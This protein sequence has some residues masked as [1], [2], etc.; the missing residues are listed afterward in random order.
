MYRGHI[1]ETSTKFETAILSIRDM[2]RLRAITGMDSMQHICIYM[3]ARYSTIKRSSSLG[4]PEHLA[5]ENIIKL[6]DT[7]GGGHAALEAFAAAGTDCLLYIFAQKFGT[8]AFGFDIK[9]GV[10]DIQIHKNILMKLNDIDVDTL[11]M[12]TDILGWIYEQHLKTGASTARDMGQFFTSRAVC[13]FMVQLCKPKMKLPGVPETVCDPTMGTGGFLTSYIKYFDK[14]YPNQVDWSIQRREIYGY[15]NDKKVACLGRLNLFMETNGTIFTNIKVMDTMVEELEIPEYDIILANMP[16]GLKGLKHANCC[17]KVKDLGIKGTKSE[18]LF[19]Q[20]MMTSLAEN[21]RCAVIVPDGVL[22]NSSSLHN[23]TRKHLVENFELKYVLSMQGKMFMN[24]NINTSI[25]FFENNGFET[26]EVEFWN[27]QVGSNGNIEYVGEG[28]SVPKDSIAATGIYSLD[29]KKYKKP[30]AI[31]VEGEYPMMRLG[32]IC[33]FQNGKTLNTNDKEIG[34][35]IPVMGGGTDYNGYYLK[36]NRDN[37]NITISKSGASAGFIKWH[38]GKFWAGD[39]FT[40][41]PHDSVNIKYL[42]YIMKSKESEIKEVV[43]GAVIPHCKCSDLENIYIPVP[44]LDKQKEIVKALDCIQNSIDNYNQLNE[45]LKEHMETMMKANTRKGCEMMRL[46]DICEFQN[47]KNITTSMFIEGIY[48]V[49]GGGKN[50][51]GYHNQYTVDENTILI[52]KD[53]S[54]GYVSMYDTKVFT[55]N[56]CIYIPNS[57]HIHEKMY[58]YYWL[59]SIQ[60]EIYKLQR[61]SIQPGINKKDLENIYIPVPPLDIQKEIVAELDNLNDMIESN[62]KNIIILNK[63][64]NKVLERYTQK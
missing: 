56:H 34:G 24:T 48:P 5:W 8:H 45:D 60:T 3:L 4:I 32:D 27:I 29:V 2:L 35:D 1:M 50:P 63:N 49:I 39:C 55:S 44:P 6:F 30:A 64:I 61:G 26:N 58:I 47:G 19:L 15:D 25:L 10:N 37:E 59:K 46:G 62:K 22:S 20:L 13:K 53:G 41:H 18:P 57:S 9:S 12:K 14:K 21:G 7:N 38:T 54:A 17:K 16:F 11:R 36:H 43:T 23:G 52:S 40:L 42:Y 28:L 31:E 51:C 33:E